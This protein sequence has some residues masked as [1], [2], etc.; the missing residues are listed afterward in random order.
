MALSS[1][2]PTAREPSG[3]KRQ[4][5]EGEASVAYG[6]WGF[7]LPVEPGEPAAGHAGH[8]ARRAL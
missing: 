7:A 4:G 5:V 8:S 3:G 2:S 1:R 6:A